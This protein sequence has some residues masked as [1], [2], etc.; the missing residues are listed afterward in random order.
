MKNS[1]NLSQLNWRVAGYVP[2]EWR[3]QKTLEIDAKPDADILPVPAK[4]PGSVQMALREADLIPDWTLGLNARHCEW[5]ENR[6]WIF[7]TLIP[8]DWIPKGRQVRLRCLGLDG[9]GLIRLNHQDIYFFRNS[10]IPHVVELTSH[11]QAENNRLQIIFECSP[12]WLGQFGRTSQM[13]EL[14]PRFNYF[15][16]WTSRL[17][18][19]GFRDDMVIEVSDG[20]EIQ[21]LTT[22]TSVDPASRTGALQISGKVR[23]D[24]ACSLHAT[25]SDGEEV[26]RAAQITPSEFNAHGWLWKELPVKLW[27]PNGLGEQPLYSF[28]IKLIDS[29][30]KKH[31]RI[32]RRLGFKHISWQPCKGAPENANPWLCV[33]NG[34]P[35]FIQGANWVPI[36]PNFA[37]VPL[38]EYRKR[39]VLYRDL[40]FNLL[41][42]W[43]GATLE[44]QCFY[45]L[46]DELGLLVW[47][48]FPLS[49]S[50]VDNVPPDDEQ[51]IA[52]FS[53]IA[54]A[55]ILLRQQH[56][57]LAI[58]CGG[59]E[60]L[61]DLERS[62]GVRE[63]PVGLDHPLIRRLH[64]IVTELDPERRFLP[65]S[66]SGP[67]F[68][69]RK[70]DFGKG[71]HWDVHG[72]W[73]PKGRLEQT[74]FPLWDEDD[75]LMHSEIGAPGSSSAE[76]IRKY[77][78]DCA[79]FPAALS[80][81]LWR[82]S[83]WWIEWEVFIEHTGREPRDL[84]E[85]VAWAQ[86]R[87]ARALSY[88]AECCKKR[89][90]AC[91]GFIIWMGH[92]CFPCTAN[93]S[94]ID[95]EGNPKP[96]AL[97]LA[98]IFKSGQA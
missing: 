32:A 71:L 66:P 21:N 10:H 60:L 23:A 44:K 25:L 75:A 29:G 47:Q 94:V 65:S 53:E 38:S 33:A 91:G 89:F 93:T 90:P 56:V 1:Y 49:S 18:Q 31:D 34:T 59:N 24:A 88:A 6:H 3:L 19:I 2:H 13:K 97:A 79:E 70:E 15:W 69:A 96:A 17:V 36:R 86:Q 92:D 7:E 82:R 9:F 62:G 67:V 37:D 68:E 5:V 84:E 30:G 16:D 72:P 63:K 81:P 12:R 28:E 35:F 11:L 41:R 73:K 74:W 58:W 77:K 78:G 14:K 57:S 46:C 98:K 95:F 39:L 4:V 51:S 48:E 87:Q 76:L 54:R 64:D 50:G 55:Y 61:W 85:Y 43:G 40:G 8:D 45:D 20:C 52:D 22:V 80:N 26:I 42:V 27:S 83:P